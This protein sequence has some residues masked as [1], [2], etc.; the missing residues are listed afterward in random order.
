MAKEEVA[1][2]LV[3]AEQFFLDLLQRFPPREYPVVFA[4]TLAEATETLQQIVPKLLL[5]PLSEKDAPR[6]ALIAAAKKAGVRILGVGDANS[7]LAEQVD[8]VAAD[9]S[10][11]VLQAVNAVLKERR[12]SPRAKVA[13]PVTLDKVGELTASVISG[14]SLFVPTTAPMRA[15]RMV[16]VTITA[17]ATTM[18]CWANVLRVQGPDEDNAE[19]AGVVLGVPEREKAIRAYL[20]GLVRGAMLI[21][22]VDAGGAAP[23]GQLT[24]NTQREI[25]VLRETIH[26][27]TTLTDALNDRIDQLVADEARNVKWKDVRPVLARKLSAQS[28]MIQE[29][30]QR[31]D[32][33]TGEEGAE[34][35][36]LREALETQHTL[37]QRVETQQFLI[38]DLRARLD[39]V[40]K[41]NTQQRE[42]QATVSRQA[43]LLALLA[44]R[45]EQLEGGE[46]R[47]VDSRAAPAA[48]FNQLAARLAHL[49]VRVEELQDEIRLGVATSQ[50]LAALKQEADESAKEIEEQLWDTS[51]PWAQVSDDEP[52]V[53][54]T[55]V[56]PF[57]PVIEPA[58]IGEFS[59]E[60]T[61]DFS[62][63]VA[64]AAM[65]TRE[66]VQQQDS[67]AE[68]PE[69]AKHLEVVSQPSG[70]SDEAPLAAPQRTLEPSL[71]PS[72][73]AVEQLEFA[74]PAASS[75][76]A[77]RIRAAAPQDE[78]PRR[79]PSWI[80]VASVFVVVAGI[81]L[82]LFF[83]LVVKDPPSKTS[84]AKTD[85]HSAI[86]QTNLD[87]SQNLPPDLHE[88]VSI[89]TGEI[90][91][92]HDAA[93]D[94]GVDDGVDVGVDD[95]VPGN[96]IDAAVRPPAKRAR[97]ASARQ[98]RRR[99]IRTASRLLRRGK[100]AKARP[101]LTKAL[102]VSDD[103]IVRWLLARSHERSGE[104]WAAIYHL[105][106]A[107]TKA[108]RRLKPSRHD[109]LGSL[110]VKVGKTAKACAEFRN[111]LSLSP[112]FGLAKKHL[113]RYCGGK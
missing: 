21:E 60:A 58:P 48:Q 86:R 36:G 55:V 26:S 22:H 89:S 64:A 88:A 19:E 42:L 94:N 56:D 71:M 4:P 47:G 87:A 10:D 43:Q 52:T 31:V 27:Q 41:A 14:R 105:S 100:A 11:A 46:V 34:P 106:K 30:L 53:P 32:S 73:D 92:G 112:D 75:L 104:N 95:G 93:I 39:A 12:S 103:Y 7:P 33:L 25:S 83:W 3:E 37:Q 51:A 96:T 79:I 17:G 18:R 63:Q 57:I 59:T 76:P 9:D 38:E 13:V 111:A 108:P 20:E 65:E 72:L 70:P 1:I 28:E 99:L 61:A 74:A 82:L 81:G 54:G 91:A 15:G 29:L 2:L 90:D 78:I 107:V 6:E 110:Y 24:G 101:Y 35:S 16:Q 77:P 40:N 44:T 85:G 97:P 68:E 67:F 113:D 23:E 109:R 84:A 102:K 66:V 62:P 45:I 50:R 80:I 49:S 98:R 69:T 8:G 5:L